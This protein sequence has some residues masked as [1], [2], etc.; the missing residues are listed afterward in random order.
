M[1][2]FSEML[3][4]GHPNSLGR[5]LEVVEIVLQDRSRL[6]ELFACYRSPDAVVRLRTSNALKRVEVERHD[7]LVPYVDRL[8]HEVGEL[9]QPSAQWTLAQLFGRLAGAMSADQRG[10]AAALMQ[11]NLSTSR[12]WIV[13]NASMDTLAEWAPSDP[14]LRTWLA[15]P[16]QRLAIDDRRSVAGRARKHLARLFPSASR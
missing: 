5:T 15:E 14:G 7:W 6:D 1:S 4:G 12:D 16:L 2:N 3:S 8:I 10:K 13:L 9:D 11:R